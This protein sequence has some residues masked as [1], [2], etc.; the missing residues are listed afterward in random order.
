M[1]LLYQTLMIDEH[2]AL[3]EVQSAGKDWNARSKYPPQFHFTHDNIF[4][5]Y[6]RALQLSQT[7]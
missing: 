6:L 4:L 2:G 5:V 3:V 7:I 1:G